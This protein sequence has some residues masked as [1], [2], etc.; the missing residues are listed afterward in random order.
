MVT[1][2]PPPTHLGPLLAQLPDMCLSD[3]GRLNQGSAAVEL[4][5]VLV[6]IFLP[7]GIILQGL[8]A[9]A[10]TNVG[11]SQLMLMAPLF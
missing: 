8:G 1:R 11:F 5:V 3:I 9:E 4:L 10:A 7:V 2:R 6:T